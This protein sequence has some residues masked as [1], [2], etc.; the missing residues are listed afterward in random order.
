VTVIQE[1]IQVILE[2]AQVDQ[3]VMKVDQGVMK[4]DQG[5]MIADHV[6]MQVIL[7]AD[8]IANHTADN[9]TLDKFSYRDQ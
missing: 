8:H 9:T 7:T 3:G 1:V 5:V 4:V 2:A 6:A